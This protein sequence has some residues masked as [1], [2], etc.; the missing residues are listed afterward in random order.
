MH[1]VGRGF[2]FGLGQLTAEPEAALSGVE[3]QGQKAIMLFMQNIVRSGDH[4]S[5]ATASGQ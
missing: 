1:G 4:R 3:R 2:R 5:P